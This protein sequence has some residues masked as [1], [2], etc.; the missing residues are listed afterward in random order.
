MNH[1]QSVTDALVLQDNPNCQGM[2]P[3]AGIYT[4]MAASESEWYIVLP[5]DTPFITAAFLRNMK[6]KLA[7]LVPC[8]GIVPISGGYEHPLTACYHRRCLPVIENLL[9]NND[10]RM[11]DLL[12]SVNIHYT[13]P[14]ND[15][16][17]PK[18][19]DNMNRKEQLYK[20][21]DV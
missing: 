20:E 4:A 2:G 21:K 19:F 13:C 11:D 5:C 15:G 3:L 1:Y 9:Q 8:D 14:E 18:L 12:K 17:A 10:L 7:E 16:F 6:I